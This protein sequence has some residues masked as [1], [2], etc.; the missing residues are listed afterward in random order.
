M[1]EKEELN[2]KV[3][4]CLANNWWPKVTTMSKSKDLSTIPTTSLFGK[5]RE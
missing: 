3:L 4:K 1:F 5:L 2:I